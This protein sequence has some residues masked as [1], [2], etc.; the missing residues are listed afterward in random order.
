MDKYERQL[1]KGVLELLVLRFVA[2]KETY[3][4]EII[5]T[6]N[7]ASGGMFCMKE[8]TLY[9][10]LYRLEDSGLIM[11]QLV[12]T[13]KGM[14]KKYYRITP[15]GRRELENRIQLWNTFYQKVNQILS[16]EI[17]REQY[18]SGSIH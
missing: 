8:G 12:D 1:K 4:Y 14:S 15:E 5:T 9:P 18:E 7:R 17:G 2:E 6:L 3:G 10:I 13:G 11:S 16:E